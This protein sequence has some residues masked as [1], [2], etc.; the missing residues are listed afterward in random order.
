MK[1][2][3][4]TRKILKGTVIR[5]YKKG[6]GYCRTQILENCE[7]F[8][9][10]K[11]SSD[12]INAVNDADPVEAYIMVDEDH[13]FEFKSEIIGKILQDPRIIFIKHTDKIVVLNEMKCLKAKTH[14]PVKFFIIDTH[15]RKK[16]HSEN[17]TI[18]DGI[19]LELSDREA[20]LSTR[21]E[22]TSG[23]FIMGHLVDVPGIEILGKVI[24]LAGENLFNISF[25]SAGEK[26]RNIILDYVMNIYR[27]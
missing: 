7:D 15:T 8:I 24:S 12:F 3:D 1:R 11:V 19:V 10:M 20:L 13:I 2:I 18:L 14:L 6:F 22:I 16:N 27:E 25:D 21:S 5:L 23:V 17:I 9:A 26:E 4:S